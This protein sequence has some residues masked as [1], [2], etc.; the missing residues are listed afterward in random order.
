MANLNEKKYENS[1]LTPL[2]AISV[3]GQ[4]FIYIS[5]SLD[6][7]F[8][9]AFIRFHNTNM[10]TKAKAFDF[11]FKLNMCDL[12]A[13]GH[14]LVQNGNI[15][16]FLNYT[17][18]LYGNREASP[19]DKYERKP[20]LAKLK[21]LIVGKIGFIFAEDNYAKLKKIVESEVI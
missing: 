7:G 13:L 10:N 11:K 9:I 21:P 1:E 12:M 15:Q 16:Y 6:R 8:P 19:N 3:N 2:Y 4:C 20:E 17:N 18:I 5:T 14:A